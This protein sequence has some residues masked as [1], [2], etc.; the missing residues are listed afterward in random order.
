MHYQSKYASKTINWLPSDTEELFNK[1]IKDPAKVKYLRESDL[2]DIKYTFNS[3][4]F[5]TAN[6]NSTECFVA[7]GCSFTVGTG[8]QEYQIWPSILS[9]RIGVPV[10]NLGVYG[11]AMDTIYRISKEY[12]H[13]IK[14]KFVTLLVPPNGRYEY[15]DGLTFK[16]IVQ[17]DDG[18]GKLHKFNSTY[19]EILTLNYEKNLMC[20]QHICN[21]LNIPFIAI[22]SDE[23]EAIDDAR[24]FMHQGPKSHKALAEK[25][26]Q[27]SGPL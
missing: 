16:V 7:L 5:R 14:P 23:F 9:E 24:D 6:I 19:D 25:F 18:Y 15:F 17:G 26:Y 27:A 11:A 10:C 21:Q 12:L 20:V 8:L 2:Y 1:T 22:H 13:T 4:G 3:Y